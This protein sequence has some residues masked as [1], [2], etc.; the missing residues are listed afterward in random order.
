MTTSSAIQILKKTLSIL[1]EAFRGESSF[2]SL[3]SYPGKVKGNSFES[4]IIW[5]TPQSLLFTENILKYIGKVG[6]SVQIYDINYQSLIIIYWNSE[7]HVR[8]ARQATK[9]YYRRINTNYPSM[10]LL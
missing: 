10:Y 8:R 6:R 1:F 9:K 7:K 4:M 3:L 2:D 5:F